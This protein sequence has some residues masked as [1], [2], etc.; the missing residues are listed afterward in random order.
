MIKKDERSCEGCINERPSPQSAKDESITEAIP[1][2][3]DKLVHVGVDSC[4]VKVLQVRGCVS[5]YACWLLDSVMLAASLA[6]EQPRRNEAHFRRKEIEGAVLV[7][8]VSMVLT[9]R[10]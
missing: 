5:K 2:A 10:G 1:N 6:W 9:V 8:V 3:V 7:E 4:L